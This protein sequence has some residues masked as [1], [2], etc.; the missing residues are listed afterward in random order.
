MAVG[1]EHEGIAVTGDEDRA[2]V[3]AE[4]IE[5]ILGAAER[6]AAAMRDEAEGILAARRADAERDAARILA[7]ARER[8]DELV[9]KEVSEARELARTLV[10]RATELLR[11]LEDADS[12]RKQVEGLLGD[13][14]DVTSRID[15][16]S[17][18]EGETNSAVPNGNGQTQPPTGKLDAIEEARLMA[19]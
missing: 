4:R 13:L 12:V 7:E 5:G 6:A 19:L 1:H 16:L 17:G 10:G 14:D 18:K 2:D 11:R 9:A 8:A 3:V 15:E